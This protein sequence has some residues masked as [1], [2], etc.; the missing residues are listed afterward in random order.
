M[1]RYPGT[2]V[3]F[4]DDSGRAAAPAPNLGEHTSEILTELGY[5]D[6]EISEIVAG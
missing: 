6:K 3:R 5:T 4:A 1:L 2:G